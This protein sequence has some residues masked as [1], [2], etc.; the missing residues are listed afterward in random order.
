MNRKIWLRA[1]AALIAGV[2]TAGVLSACNGREN[3]AVP[4]QKPSGGDSGAANGVVSIDTE[5]KTDWEGQWIWD[6]DRIG[7]ENTWLVFR[8]EVKLDR[9]PEKL[10]ANIA[11]DSRYWLYING[12]NVVY[13]G[14][15]KRGPDGESGYYDS[16][17]IAPYL[18]KGENVIAAEVWYWGKDGSFSYI[19]SGVGGFLFEAEEDKYTDGRKISIVSDSGWK[20]SAD[21]AYQNDTGDRQPNYRIAEFNIL[22]DAREALGDFNAAD[23][24]DSDWKPASVLCAG[25]EDP[26]GKL[27]PRPIPFL[28]VAE[29]KD[30]ENSS[31]YAGITTK[32]TSYITLD[33]PYNAQCVPYL[34]VEC[35][36]GKTIEITTENTNLGS[37]ITRYVTTD[38]RQE[39]ESKGWFNGEHISYKIPKDVKIIALKYRESG[40]NT[41]FTG[42]F[43][44]DDEFM[45]TLW[46]K[47]LRTLYVTMRDNFMDCPD[48]ERAQWWGDVTNEMA[49]T[50][51]SMD[52]NSYLLYLKGV[53]NMLS[54][55]ENNVLETV[56]PAG[57]GVYFELP[58]QQL[59]GI[60]GFKTYY[61]YTGDRDFVDM[62]YEASLNYV[63][64]WIQGPDGL[65]VHR[66]GS[67]DWMDWGDGADVVCIENA[68]YYKALGTV[69]Y[70]ASVKGDEEAVREL[71]ERMDMLYGSYQ[72]LWTSK[73]FMG[74]VKRP[75][76]RA[77][78]LAVLSGLAD[79]DNPEQFGTIKKVL[80]SVKNSSPYMERYVLDALCEMGL[81]EEAAE[82]IRSRYAGMVAEDYSTLWEFWDKSSG[83][84]N[85]A[86]SGGPLLTMSQYIA[87]VSPVEPGY[88]V[89]S[90]RPALGS[91]NT[92]SCTVP[93]V[94]GN[95][96]VN[97]EKGDTYKLKIE[98]PADTEVIACVP[99]SGAGKVIYLDGVKIFENGAPAGSLPENVSF[100]GYEDGRACFKVKSGDSG[101]VLNFEVKEEKTTVSEVSVTVIAPENGKISV[102]GE[103]FESGS[104]G[105]LKVSRGSQVALGAEAAPGHEFAYY[106]GSAAGRNAKQTLTAD[107]DLT[108]GVVFSKARSDYST[109]TVY[110]PEGT[111]I[112]IKVNGRRCMFAGGKAAITVPTG[113]V[114]SVEAEDGILGEFLNF[115]G[116]VQTE[117]RSVSFTVNGNTDLMVNSRLRYGENIARGAKATCSVSLE[118]GTT[119]SVSNLTD[120]NNSTGF[121]TE[122]LKAV[123]GIL[124]KP[125]IINL[126][127][128]SVKEFSLLSLVPRTDTVSISG[129][130]PCFPLEF[131]VKVSRGGSDYTDVGTFTQESD[132]A[133]VV[134]SYELGTVK[135]RFVRIEIKRVGDYAA[136]EGVAD[137]YRA[138][139]MEI[140]LRKKN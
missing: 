61:M 123:D 72:L 37:V 41:E 67:W 113:S 111:D 105:T 57:Y 119:W 16:I 86:W 71:T 49:M 70:F 84:M 82:R 30:Y 110:T 36:A 99:S 128:G 136:D 29:L 118:S 20:V 121:T 134:Q 56:V 129:G 21:T 65:V 38:G 60:C 10:V 140:M 1:A 46:Q 62:V 40:Y 131:T 25:G 15:L 55:A 102:N 28:K 107:T 26:F 18:K 23:F 81:V 76:D 90:V 120:G 34:C 6:F 7:K 14:G 106:I 73:G 22:Y 4:T 91:L 75:D 12:V 11:A 93:S 68:W 31:D 92:V 112:N 138:Q 5:P 32:S 52:S 8:K 3:D 74:S 69:R 77:N 44:C 103:M 63:N 96:I 17:D 51:Y 109:L 47:S 116:P 78:A 79:L 53:F 127:L 137:P 48:R 83:T 87:G 101:K 59:A 9:V 122:V 43:T 66:S 88:S 124:N 45:N 130:N 94:K 108:V 24:D 19:D 85:H 42:N 98:S 39:F 117:E 80:T 50:M 114:V 27:Y 33:I 54:S 58:M 125:V 97:V 13:E 126:D 115:S 139:I 95:I 104:T 89:Y 135:A 133:G 35:E 100:Y 64:L 2:L 132:P